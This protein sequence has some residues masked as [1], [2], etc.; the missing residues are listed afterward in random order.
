[1]YFV[2]C[3]KFSHTVDTCNVVQSAGLCGEVENQALSPSS[4]TTC[5]TCH[6]YLRENHRVWLCLVLGWSQTLE[7]L[8]VNFFMIEHLHLK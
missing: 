8:S 3:F 7:A 6:R 5:R 4:S 2:L 1:M